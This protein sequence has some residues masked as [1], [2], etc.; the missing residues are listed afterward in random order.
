M[1]EIFFFFFVKDDDDE[2]RHEKKINLKSSKFYLEM[3]QKKKKTGSV[4]VDLN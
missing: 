1:N 4:D 2:V 3:H